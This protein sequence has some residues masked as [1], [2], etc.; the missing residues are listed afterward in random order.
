MAG[1]LFSVALLFASGFAMIWGAEPAVVWSMWLAAAAS[2]F[3]GAIF[4]D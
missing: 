1:I 2:A 3:F 4:A